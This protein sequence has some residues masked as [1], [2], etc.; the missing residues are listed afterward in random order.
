MDAA[1]FLEAR[2]W[3]SHWRRRL[4]C[5]WLHDAKEHLSFRG[6]AGRAAGRVVTGLVSFAYFHMEHAAPDEEIVAARAEA[7]QREISRA[8]R[9]EAI[10]NAWRRISILRREGEPLDGQFTPWLR[11]SR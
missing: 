11:K 6:H 8:Q 7:A 4:S 5:Y 9:R 3:T 10:W 1:L 2:I